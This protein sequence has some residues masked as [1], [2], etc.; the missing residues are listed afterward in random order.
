MVQTQVDVA[1]ITIREDEF[2][3]VLQRFTQVEPQEGDSGRIYSIGQVQTKTGKS[4]KV[5][6][7]RCS[8]PG[9]D[10]SQ[11][12]ASDMMR[13]LDPQLLLVVGI[14]G[15]IPHKEFTLGDVIIS[16]RIHNFN[17]SASNQRDISFDVRGGIHP[18][19]SNITA[20]LPAYK[21]SLG[22]WNNLDSIGIARPSVDLSKA[23]LNVYG[24]PKWRE[25]VIESLNA[26]FDPTA[27]PTRLPLFKT[28]SIASSNTLMKETEIPTTWLRG[29][30]SMLAIEMESAGVLQAAQQTNTQYPV[31]AI[32]GISDIV[33][34]KRDDRWTKYACQTAAA[35]AYAFVTAGIITPRSI[36]TVTHARAS[37]PTS[38][39]SP[40]PHVSTQPSQP[41]NAQQIDGT[42][43]IEVF[44]SYA[45]E[46]EK[47]K[48]ELDKH[49]KMLTRQNVIHSVHSQSTE[50]GIERQEDV[51][52]FIE[53]AQIILLLISKDFLAS[54]RLYDY[55]LKQAMERHK[56]GAARV[57]PIILR[58]ANLTDTPFEGLQSLPRD[59]KPVGKLN[60]DDA[61]S[62][63]SR[64]IRG[65]CDTLRK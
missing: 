42:G 54:D 22:N 21:S 15:G 62:K 1:I 57:I 36:S 44:I 28:G 31:M 30:R 65:I 48:L 52:H 13:D 43:P 7:A 18:R 37:T 10:V 53:A 47:F 39:S 5:A 58:P 16:S 25:D 26:H 32:R 49:L 27:G 24:D 46:D 45:P 29:A 12:V 20:S 35:F 38:I 2:E 19:I 11:Q 55:E 61:W 64:E 6:I 17:V 63:I 8:E 33:G 4:C 34:L 9:N 51:A 14:A 40:V 50:A 59:T 41:Q 60:N 3:A 56:I 23:Q